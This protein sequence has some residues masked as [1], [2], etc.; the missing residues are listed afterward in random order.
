MKLNTAPT[1]TVTGDTS[2]FTKA[3]I[4]DEDLAAAITVMSVNYSRPFEAV[5][6]ETVTNGIDAV[7]RAGLDPRD[8]PVII[9]APDPVGDSMF[10]VKDYGTGMDAATLTDIFFNVMA[11]TKR[12]DNLAHGGFGIGAKAPYAVS[13]SFTIET[14]VFDP[15]TRTQEIRHVLCAHIDET[16]SAKIVAEHTVVHDEKAL[17]DADTN[18]L[19]YTVVSVPTSQEDAPRWAEAIKEVL[20]W[21]TPGYFTLGDSAN[22]VRFKE[23]D[24]IDAN[25]RKKLSTDR[26]K[27]VDK[28]N[29][30]GGINKHIRMGQVAYDYPNLGANVF[31]D[32]DIGEVTVPQTRESIME[33]RANIQRINEVFAEER[34]K[35]LKRFGI[36]DYGE[37]EVFNRIAHTFLVRAVTGINDIEKLKTRTHNVIEQISPMHAGRSNYMKA[38]LYSKGPRCKIHLTDSWHQYKDTTRLIPHLHPDFVARHNAHGDVDAWC[39]EQGVVA[40]DEA[41]AYPRTTQGSP[42]LLFDENELTQTQIRKLPAVMRTHDATILLLSRK[43]FAASKLYSVLFGASNVEAENNDPDG[44]PI[45]AWTDP[46]VIDEL[47]PKKS[48]SQAATLDELLHQY[49]KITNNAKYTTWT[50]L[51][52]NMYTLQE[53]TTVQ[54]RDIEAIIDD[55]RAEGLDT[56]IVN[57]EKTIMPTTVPYS[58]TTVPYSA[59]NTVRIITMFE[60]ARTIKKIA[61]HYDVEYINND[62]A[63]GAAIWSRFVTQ[64][65]QGA[66]PTH[67]AILAAVLRQSTTRRVTIPSIQTYAPAPVIVDYITDALADVISDV[68]APIEQRTYATCVM[69]ELLYEMEF[70]YETFRERT[71]GAVETDERGMI[72]DDLEHR[73]HILPRQIKW[74]AALEAET[75]ENTPA[76]AALPACTVQYRAYPHCVAVLDEMLAMRAH[77]FVETFTRDQVRDNIIEALRRDQLAKLVAKHTNT[78]VQG[79]VDLTD[80]AVYARIVA[81]IED[82][83]A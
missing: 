46:A 42:V 2:G 80:D 77:A 70:P 4:R 34:Q 18:T 32:L 56:V 22:L 44:S 48:N 57:G 65:T 10:T 63:L 39:D 27:V 83:F 51:F 40:H 71:D 37:I 23:N 49:V 3:R 16:P 8:Y 74:G 64:H 43:A 69:I 31:L 20:T 21:L 19:S 68:S 6:R 15:A 73:L 35:V 30:W 81:S 12:G 72:F 17:A 78:A 54:V 14:A 13:D 66:H 50:A 61:A 26:L 53:R 55:A 38:Y 41:H 47:A 45:L 79:G 7:M 62:Q 60:P 1:N 11:S 9:T 67:P 82:A 59:S 58:A 24:A 28:K 52:N 29:S 36:T 25:I 33:T 75:L 5:V 76:L